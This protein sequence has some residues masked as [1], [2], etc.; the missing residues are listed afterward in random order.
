MKKN[1]LTFPPV[2]GT[3]ESNQKH[4]ASLIARQR[5]AQQSAHPPKATP[6]ITDVLVNKLLVLCSRLR[7]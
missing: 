6:R 7:G 1:K 3:F 4:R 5:A 2:I